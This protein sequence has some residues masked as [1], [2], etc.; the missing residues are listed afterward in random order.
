MTLACLKPHGM[1]YCQL[2]GVLVLQYGSNRE[3]IRNIKLGD[4][5]HGYKTRETKALWQ[6]GYRGSLHKC[7]LSCVGLFASP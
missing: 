1:V 3:F 4:V 2:S 7:V 5:D 6:G